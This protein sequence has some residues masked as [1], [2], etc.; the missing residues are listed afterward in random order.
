VR[1]LVAVNSGEYEC[2]SLRVKR[3]EAIFAGRLGQEPH[4]GG[5][6]FHIVVLHG[7]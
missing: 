6:I 1:E 4:V 3:L 7:R 5:I 2:R